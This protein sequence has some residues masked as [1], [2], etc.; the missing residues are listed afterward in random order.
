V[1]PAAL[2]R[3]LQRWLERRD[4]VFGTDVPLRRPGELLEPVRA[5]G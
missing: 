1:Q 5:A 2:D 4:V 3:V